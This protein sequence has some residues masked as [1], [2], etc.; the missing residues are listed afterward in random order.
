MTGLHGVKHTFVTKLL[1]NILR[2]ISTCFR[3]FRK[4]V[5]KKFKVKLDD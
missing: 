5:H 1:P 2:E 3:S 4:Y